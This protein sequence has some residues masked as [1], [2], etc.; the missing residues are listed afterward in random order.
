MDW[1]ACDYTASEHPNG[2]LMS[3]PAGKE[4]KELRRAA[5]ALAEQVFGDWDDPQAKAHMYQWL[6]KNTQSG[7]IGKAS[8]SELREIVK[9]LRRKAYKAKRPY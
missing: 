4:I 6:A 8:E 2:E 1:P 3:N 9:L 7:H 5:H